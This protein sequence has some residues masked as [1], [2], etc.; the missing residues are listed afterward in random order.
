MTALVVFVA[1]ETSDSG[2]LPLGIHI[3]LIHIRQSYALAFP[4][5]CVGIAVVAAGLCESVFTQRLVLVLL[6][7]VGL[8]THH[9]S[10]ASDDELVF[11]QL[12]DGGPCFGPSAAI[13]GA[14]IPGEGEEVAARQAQAIGEDGFLFVLLVEEHTPDVVGA[15]VLGNEW[16]EFSQGGISGSDP[17]CLSLVGVLN[18]EGA[19]ADGVVASHHIEGPGG[20]VGSEAYLGDEE[21]VVPQVVLFHPVLEAIVVEVGSQ[22][23]DGGCGASPHVDEVGE[24]TCRRVFAR[25]ASAAVHGGVD[26]QRYVEYSSG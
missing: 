25:L 13:G 3:H 15:L 10:S 18:G 19:D 12:Q 21:R 1:I 24:G 14:G 6:F 23:V 5:R 20:V 22:Q 2:H 11:G 16:G 8:E 9:Y 4:S 17:R 7:G 26:I